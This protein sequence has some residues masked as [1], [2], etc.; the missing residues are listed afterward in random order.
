[1]ASKSPYYGQS[2]ASDRA[3]I[4]MAKT[5]DLDTITKN[6]GRKPASIL[7]TAM[8]LGIAIKRPKAKTK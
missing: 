8:R 5:M 4:D 1:M 6:I 3:L 7:K 2:M